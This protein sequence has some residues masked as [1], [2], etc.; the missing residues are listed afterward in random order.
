MPGDDPGF[1]GKILYT[2]SIKGVFSPSDFDSAYVERS[3]KAPT[4]SLQL[5]WV[6]GY[7]GQSA[8]G[9]VRY[10]TSG[11]VVNYS[12]SVAV[13]LD[14]TARTQRLSLIHI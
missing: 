7:A 8:R 5:E 13:A 4:A 12:A 11:E 1:D 6:H 14:K 10:N 3:S 2:K 9:N